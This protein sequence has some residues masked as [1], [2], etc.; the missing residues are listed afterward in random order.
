MSG[1]GSGDYGSGDYGG[2]FGAI[3]AIPRIIL[4]TTASFVQRVFTA[5]F[6]KHE[7][8]AAVAPKVTTAAISLNPKYTAAV[9]AHPTYTAA[10]AQHELTAIVGS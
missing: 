1:Y 4:P 8:S 7:L 3:L 2:I 5:A 6:G 9:A 10:V